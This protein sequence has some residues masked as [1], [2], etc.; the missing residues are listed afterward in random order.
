M[1]IYLVN[2]RTREAQDSGLTTAEP[3]I[4]LSGKT[5]AFLRCEAVKSDVFMGS[6]EALRPGRMFLRV[7]PGLPGVGWPSLHW[8]LGPA[9]GS[10]FAHG[11]LSS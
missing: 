6:V 11:L 5:T 7:R 2:S 8:D 3:E 10:S 9:Q 4:L 1:V